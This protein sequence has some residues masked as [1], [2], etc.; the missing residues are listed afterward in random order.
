MS[1]DLAAVPPGQVTTPLGDDTIVLSGSRLL[2]ENA[3][4]AILLAPELFRIDVRPQGDGIQVV[5]RNLTGGTLSIGGSGYGAPVHVSGA[6]LEARRGLVSRHDASFTI[7]DEDGSIDV[8]L[9]YTTIRDPDE[10]TV[11]CSAQARVRH[12]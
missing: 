10:G 11:R 4:G 12:R 6:W 1:P 3:R 9:V 2:H 5:V 8:E 7:D